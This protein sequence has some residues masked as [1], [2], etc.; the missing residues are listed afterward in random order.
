[1]GTSKSIPLKIKPKDS[2]DYLAVMSKAVFQAG[3]SWALI[4]SRWLEFEAAFENFN[5]ERVSKFNEAKIS[6]IIENPKL[7]KSERKVRAT[8]HNAATMAAIDTEYDGFRN[9]LRSF[10][11]YSEL[12]KDLRKRFK[13]FGELSVYYFLFRVGESVPEFTSWVTTIEGHHPRMKEM[14]ELSQGTPVAGK[15]GD[16]LNS[17]RK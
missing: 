7:F 3:V 12:S 9:Y 13:N 4:D 16:A 10:S 14:V 5:P 2:S 8:I 15:P 11:S 6:E 1:M 17:V